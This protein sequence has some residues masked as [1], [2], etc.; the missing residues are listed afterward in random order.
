MCNYNECDEKDAA[1]EVL[2]TLAALGSL[3]SI[4]FVG[5]IE[6]RKF[7]KT[8]SS[9]FSAQNILLKVFE[10]E[11]DQEEM[12]DDS[13]DSDYEFSLPDELLK[14]IEKLEI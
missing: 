2:K 13:D 11:D 6:S 1:A 8:V 7:N 14:K 10:E 4:D 5:N 3:K 12:D 9:A